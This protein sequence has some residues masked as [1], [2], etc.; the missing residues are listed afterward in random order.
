[1][2][3]FLP[4]ELQEEISAYLSCPVLDTQR[5]TEIGDTSLGHLRKIPTKCG[6]EEIAHKRLRKADL[7]E[8]NNRHKMMQVAQHSNY[9]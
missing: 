3:S 8:V 2:Q 4:D 9:Y 5:A 1:M 6:L 7:E